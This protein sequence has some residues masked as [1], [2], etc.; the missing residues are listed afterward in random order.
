MKRALHGNDAMILAGAMN[1]KAAVITVDKLNYQPGNLRI[2]FV[3]I[4]RRLA[5]LSPFCA[6]RAP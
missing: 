6:T 4:W 3:T 1:N 5:V 2:V